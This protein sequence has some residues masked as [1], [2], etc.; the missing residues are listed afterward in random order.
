MKHCIDTQRHGCC[1]AEVALHLSRRIVGAALLICVV[2]VSALGGFKEVRAEVADEQTAQESDDAADGATNEDESALVTAETEAAVNKAIAFLAARQREDGSFGSDKAGQNDPAF[3]AL[4][5]MALLAAGSKPGEGPYGAELQKALDYLLEQ[6]QD[7]GFI[8]SG[9]SMYIHAYALR[10]LAQAQLSHKTPRLEKAI[11]KAVALI[12]TSQNSRDGWRYSPNSQDA[13]SS[14]TACQ[15]IALQAAR[16]AGAKVPEATLQRAVKYLKR[17][18]MPDGGFA[19][20]LPGNESALP[21]SA[22]VMAALYLSEVD[23]EEVKKGLAYLESHATPPDSKSP[24]FFFTQFHLSTALRYAGD[25]RFGRWYKPSRDQLL[26]MQ[27]ADGSWPLQ[28]YGPE[29]STAKACIV[30]LSPQ[31]PILS[32]A[33]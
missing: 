4:C 25:K 13:D 28:H 29:Y 12:V 31:K 20:V 15:V 3:T 7:N 11:A 33:E 14:V 26:K 22:G 9:G 32:A 18:Q 24:Y 5:G 8:G 1:L 2:I 16:R 10:F 19:Y 30:L 27:S 17:C 23:S 21:R 6:V